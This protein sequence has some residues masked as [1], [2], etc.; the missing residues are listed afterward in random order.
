MIKNLVERVFSVYIDFH[1]H[2][3]THG[4]DPI[5]DPSWSLM[6]SAYKLGHICLTV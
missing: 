5:T 1:V 6:S 4:S 2:K 3:R